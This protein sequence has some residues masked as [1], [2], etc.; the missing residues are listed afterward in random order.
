MTPKITSKK[1]GPDLMVYNTEREEVHFLNPTAELIYRLCQEGKSEQEI[2][3]AVCKTF[4]IP[5]T[6]DIRGDIA[7]CLASLQ[8][9]GLVGK[10]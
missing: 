8:T 1:I 9:S 6:Q 10:P 2:Q 7:K 4:D 3:E 5:E